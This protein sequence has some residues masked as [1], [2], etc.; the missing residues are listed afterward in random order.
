MPEL[1][2]YDG[3]EVFVSRRGQVVGV[4]DATAA[5]GLGVDEDDDVFVGR[6]GQLVVHVAEV[7]G[8]EVAF[9]VEGVEV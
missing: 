5:V 4:V 1:V 9:A 6:A 7:E 3:L 8:G 2:H